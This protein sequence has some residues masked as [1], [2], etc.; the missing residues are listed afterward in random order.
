MNNKG[1]GRLFDRSECSYRPE[2]DTFRCPQVGL[3]RPIIIAERSCSVLRRPTRSVRDVRTEIAMHD[4][5]AGNCCGYDVPS[6]SIRL[7]IGKTSS[8]GIRA[9]CFARC[10]EHKRKSVWPWS[11]AY[12]LK[13]ARNILGRGK[14]TAALR[15]ARSRCYAPS[16]DYGD[17]TVQLLLEPKAM[18]RN[19]ELR[20]HQP[21]SFSFLTVWIRPAF[22]V[23]LYRGNFEKAGSSLRSE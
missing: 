16:R 5:H 18:F 4:A 19:P 13:R 1:D 22:F 21:L 3:A 20:F 6:W 10:G 23:L 2:C 8:S 12:N 7:R 15:T 14:L 9:S 17:V 11:L